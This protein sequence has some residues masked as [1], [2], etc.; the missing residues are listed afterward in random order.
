MYKKSFLAL[1]DKLRKA[2]KGLIDIFRTVV[3]WKSNV[4]R[5]KTDITFNFK[6]EIIEIKIRDFHNLVNSNFNF[7]DFQFIYLV[8]NN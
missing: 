2:K 8:I 7:F 4:K 6:R 5:H 3:Y 1:Q